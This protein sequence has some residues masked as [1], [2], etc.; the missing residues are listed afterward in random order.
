VLPS[1]YRR[2]DRL[3]RKGDAKQ[4]ARDIQRKRIDMHPSYFNR[5]T[6]NVMFGEI[7][8]KCVETTEVRFTQI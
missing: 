7:L 6:S 5:L 4:P 1:Y 3:A 2:F 8:W